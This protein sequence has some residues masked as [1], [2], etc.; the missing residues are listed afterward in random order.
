MST[1]NTSKKSDTLDIRTHINGRHMGRCQWLL[2]ILCFIIVA[3][4]GI[5]VAIMGFLAPDIIREMGISRAAFGLVMSAAPV[6]LAIGAILVGPLS[7]RLGRKKPLMTAIFLFGLFNLLGAFTSN[8]IE[9][10][11]LRFLTGLGL[12]AAMPITTTLFSEYIPERLRS[13]LIAIMFTGFGLGSAVVGFGAAALL[14]A[15][16]WRFVMMLGGAIPLVC[17]PFYLW[18]IPE[19]AQFLVVKKA[20]AVKVVRVLRRALGGDYTQYTQFSTSERQVQGKSPVT[21]LLAPG[22]RSMTLSLWLTYFMGLLVIYLLSG[23]MP[24][25][26]KDAGLPIS[27]AAN[28]TAM[29]QL[30]GTVGC[31]TVGLFMDRWSPNKVI[32]LAYFGGAAFV[33]MLAIV[34]LRSEYLGVYILL[35]GFC[36]NG[37]QTGLNAFAPGCYPTS[38]RATGVSWMLGIGRFGSIFGSAIGGV[39]LSAGFGFGTVIALLAI[40]AALAGLTIVRG[41]VRPGGVAQLGAAVPVK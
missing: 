24:T 40:P 25:L 17:L 26:M 32:A 6:G 41:S 21:A 37:A 36:M 31:I 23:W 11:A 9:L 22:T 12:G 35:A 39:L 1:T 13:S 14:P 28:L 4:D 7:D 5:D 33:L 10:A 19:S 3:T 2:L 20:A 16:G 34:G 8:H 15:H 38:N 29:F 18:L 30:G 27:R